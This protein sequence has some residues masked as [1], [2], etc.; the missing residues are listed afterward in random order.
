ML[1]L[2]RDSD[3][4]DPDEDPPS[5]PSPPAPAATP[6]GVRGT[7]GLGLERLEAA[8]PTPAGDAL[9]GEG[10]GRVSNKRPMSALV[11]WSKASSMSPWS[12]LSRISRRMEGDTMPGE[13]RL[14]ADDP[15]PAGFTDV[16]GCEGRR[17]PSS[18]AML[19]VP[20]SKSSH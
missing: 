4:E 8:L 3:E 5:P 6:A 16:E 14:E 12:P 7:P 1:R 11:H 20:R 10:D 2:L 17:D 13:S 9:A 18:S 19:V 15:T